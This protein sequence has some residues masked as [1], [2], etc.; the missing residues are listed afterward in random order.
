MANS[1]DGNFDD[2]KF[3]SGPVV[4]VISC[5]AAFDEVA[6]LAAS[7]EG[8]TPG[9]LIGIVVSLGSSTFD[10]I[11]I[12]LPNVLLLATLLTSMVDDGISPLEVDG[13][14]ISMVS[15][16]SIVVETNTSGFGP[17]SKRLFNN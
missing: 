5:E 14:D 6:K 15:L 17:L 4:V 2:G 13:N 16:P 3:E 8:E 10:A 7:L 1:G 9:L 11:F 12:L